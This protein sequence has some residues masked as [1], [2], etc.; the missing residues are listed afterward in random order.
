MPWHQAHWRAQPARPIIGGRIR[1]SKAGRA[2]SCVSS[3]RSPPPAKC[4]SNGIIVFGP[5]RAGPIQR[6]ASS[7]SIRDCSIMARPRLTGLFDTNWLICWLSFGRAVAAFHRMAQ[8]G[9]KPVANSESETNRAAIIFPSPSVGTHHAFST[10]ARIV[11][12]TFHAF[13]ESDAP[14][15]VWR[16]AGNTV[17]ANTPSVFG[18]NR[19]PDSDAALR[20]PSLTKDA[21]N[22][23]R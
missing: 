4:G 5:A 13:V 16:V 15:P 2:N 22:P 18:S 14:S 3:G 6:A 9:R 20:R 7:P 23:Y 17:A 10:G 21:P 19:F 11:A 12:A 8:N 1:F